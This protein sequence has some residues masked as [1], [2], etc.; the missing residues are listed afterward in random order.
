MLIDLKL[1]KDEKLILEEPNLKCQVEND[2]VYFQIEKVEHQLD[3]EKKILERFNEEFHFYLNFEE[4]I[5]T[6]EL[7]SHQ[8][9]FDIIVD[10]SYFSK[11]ENKIEVE[12]AIET[13]DAKTK[14]LIELKKEI[15]K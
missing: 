1:Y 11:I 14:I 5:C 6:Y 9:V 8:A 2:T 7:K 15:D 3:F 13:D 4:E 10:Q 12:Y